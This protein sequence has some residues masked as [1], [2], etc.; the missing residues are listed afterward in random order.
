MKTIREVKGF[1]NFVNKTLRFKYCILL[2]T[3]PWRHLWV[4]IVTLII[5]RTENVIGMHE[6]WQMDPRVGIS[7]RVEHYDC[8]RDM[9]MLGYAA[10]IVYVVQLLTHSSNV[11]CPALVCPKLL[12]YY[13][14]TNYLTWPFKSD[15][16]NTTQIR[17]ICTSLTVP[18]LA[19][20]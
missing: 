8:A 2:K 15:H 5:C 18:T 16:N 17:I 6:T 13:L 14:C 4:P 9:S 3:R 7:L 11:A 1:V 20:H 10:D 19:G 12:F